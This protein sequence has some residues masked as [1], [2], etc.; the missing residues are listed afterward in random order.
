MLLTYL[1]NYAI[2]ISQQ[3]KTQKQKAA[4]KP[5]KLNQRAERKKVYTM[6]IMEIVNKK[7]D[8]MKEKRRGMPS[9]AAPPVLSVKFCEMSYP[10][11]GR[12]ET[13]TV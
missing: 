6:K 1:L 7:A 5:E 9:Q 4:G 10:A 13:T 2:I 3:R 8:M 12:S 11:P